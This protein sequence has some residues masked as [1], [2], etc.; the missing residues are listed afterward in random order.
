MLY[1]A[2]RVVERHLPGLTQLAQEKF[3]NLPTSNLC[4]FVNLSVHPL[5]LDLYHKDEILLGTSMYGH[6]PPF[7]IRCLEKIWRDLDRSCKSETVT[8]YPAVVGFYRSG[9]AVSIYAHK[10][11]VQAVQPG[12]VAGMPE[13]TPS[14]NGR[15][16]CVTGEDGGKDLAT[17]RDIA[18]SVFCNLDFSNPDEWYMAGK[19]SAKNLYSQVGSCLTVDELE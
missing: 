8:T 16:H 3:P 14:F 4:L 19:G 18:D 6:L 12:E 9:P 5:N 11:S 1:I 2:T 17:R 15:Q 10:I 13:D 7:T